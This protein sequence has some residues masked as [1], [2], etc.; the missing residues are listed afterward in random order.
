MLIME[1]IL[2]SLRNYQL[3]LGKGEKKIFKKSLEFSRQGGG[4]EL[5][6]PKKFQTFF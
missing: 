5:P 1:K 3:K 4:G 6:N 2:E